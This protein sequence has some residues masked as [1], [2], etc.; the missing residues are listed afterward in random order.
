VATT[1]SEHA[2]LQQQLQA[3]RFQLSTLKSYAFEEE[4]APSR[5]ELVAK[6]KTLQWKVKHYNA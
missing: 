2:Y 3:V 5:E 1:Q 4:G 6:L